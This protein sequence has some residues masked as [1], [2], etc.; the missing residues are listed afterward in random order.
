MGPR[1]YAVLAVL[2]AFLCLTPKAHTQQPKAKVD[3]T[4]NGKVVTDQPQ[5]KPQTI[6]IGQ[7]V[8]LAFTVSGAAG[9]EISVAGDP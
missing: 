5:T 4:F 8:N 2:A 9:L 6:M 1:P 7:P 3:I